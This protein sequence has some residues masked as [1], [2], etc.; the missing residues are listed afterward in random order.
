MVE[1]VRDSAAETPVLT[2]AVL[3]NDRFARKGIIAE[4]ESDQIAVAGYTG[5]ADEIV[6]IVAERQPD[7]VIID[8]KL[9]RDDEEFLGLG[10]ISAIKQASPYT[11]CIV[12]TGFPTITNF[13]A[14]VLAGAEGFIAKEN[15]IQ[16][17]LTMGEAVRRAV[18]GERCYDGDLVAQFVMLAKPQPAI[19]P[20]LLTEREQEVLRMAD[21]SN[22]DIA[23]RLTL[24]ESTVKA[25]FKNAFEKLGQVA[26]RK[27]LNR[28]DAAEV[29]RVLGFLES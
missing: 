27:I 13:R 2:V 11:R 8:L 6:Q 10:V 19:Q 16:V 28:R 7:A 22:E 14:S 12:V 25:H 21:L 4:L 20:N 29:A 17:G 5:D 18:R 15:S 9:S 26:G 24:A 3:E 1:T 23:D